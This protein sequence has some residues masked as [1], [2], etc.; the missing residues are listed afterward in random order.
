LQQFVVTADT[1]DVTGVTATL[2]ISP[3]IITSGPLQT[4]DASPANDAVVTVVGATSAAGGTLATTV[5]PQGLL[6][7][8]DAFIL[9]TADLD[10]NLDGATVERVS[11]KKLNISLRYVRQYSAM[12]DQKAARIDGLIGWSPFRPEWAVRIQS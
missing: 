6:Y 2:P 3:S 11:S 8:P 7:H 12:T 4:V 1:L 10:G 5:R 9:A